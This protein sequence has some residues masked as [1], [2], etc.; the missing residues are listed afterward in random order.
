MEEVQVAEQVAELEEWVF[1]LNLENV[2]PSEEAQVK[3]GV[4]GQ[5][6]HER[7]DSRVGLD[8]VETSGELLEVK[9]EKAGRKIE[10]EVQPRAPEKSHKRSVTTLAGTSSL[11]RVKQKKAPPQFRDSWERNSGPF[12]FHA[13]AALR[14]SRRQITLILHV[15]QLS[16]ST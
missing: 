2:G 6:K 15:T 12:T 8:E 3:Q 16:E 14:T 10:E 5:L 13:F 11:R 4:E 7:E 9:E 1:G